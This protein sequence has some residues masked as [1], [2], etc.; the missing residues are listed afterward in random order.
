MTIDQEYQ[1]NGPDGHGGASART[2][3]GA[4]GSGAITREG[5][6]GRC[7]AMQRLRARIEA[8]AQ[9]SATVLLTGESGTGKELGARAIHALS[10]RRDRTLVAV[11]CAALPETLLASEL[12]GHVR[13][14][15]TGAIAAR[16]GRFEEAHRGTL[17]L[18]EVAELSLEAQA[19]LLRAIQEGTL[20]PIGSNRTVQVDVRVIAATNRPFKRILGEGRFRQ[21]LYYR[22]KVLEV[23]I[24]PLRE[25]LE[26]L[27]MLVAHFLGRLSRPGEPSP[28]LSPRAWAA[29]SHYD[30]PGNVRELA[31]ALEQAVVLSGG[32]E[33]GL[34]HLPADVRGVEVGEEK[35]ASST[36]SVAIQGFEREYVLRALALADGNRANAAKLLGISRKSLWKKMRAHENPGRRVSALISGDA[37]TLCAPAWK[38]PRIFGLACV[39]SA[40]RPDVDVTER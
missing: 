19:Q 14:A 17:F 21:D 29:L 22:L 12:F 37:F 6:V 40:P 39:R 33:I 2:A 27:P 20:H 18:D 26:D 34:L 16:K 35:A 32:R 36:L 28:H 23:H 11:N 24:P 4:L 10:P 9:S 8:I 7:E 25:R 38:I 3:T 31:H 5:L 1:E 30:W 13:G 15:F